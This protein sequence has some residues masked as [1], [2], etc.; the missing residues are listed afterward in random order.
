MD[1]LMILKMQWEDPAGNHFWDNAKVLLLKDHLDMY[2]SEVADTWISSH[3]VT[4]QK[5]LRSARLF[6]D[7][8]N[9]YLVVGTDS[10]AVDRVWME[11]AYSE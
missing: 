11:L 7:G 5:G 4:W 9:I 2:T 10:N 1:N 6:R 8:V 3:L